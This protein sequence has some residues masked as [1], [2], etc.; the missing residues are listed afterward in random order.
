MGSE[1]RPSS[2]GTP[3]APPAPQLPAQ[4]AQRP[5]EQSLHPA[6]AKGDYFGLQKK[7]N[8]QTKAIYTYLQCPPS[9]HWLTR[10]VSRSSGCSWPPQG[11]L[12][13][14][15]PQP[16]GT[17]LGISASTRVQPVPIVQ[18]DLRRACWPSAGKMVPRD[19]TFPWDTHP[20]HQDRQTSASCRHLEPA[21]ERPALHWFW[22][23]CWSSL[24]KNLIRRTASG[25]PPPP[26]AGE[27]GLPSQR[28]DPSHGKGKQKQGYSKD[29]GGGSG[30]GIDLQSTI[31]KNQLETKPIIYSLICTK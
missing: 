14:A 30:L 10:D 24:A 16:E 11:R 13:R 20:L 26:R 29:E 7:K 15:E 23:S 25:P 1:G 2:E 6:N 8:E 9:R 12:Q 27:P 18:Q 17:V 22:V 3:R 28:R 19:R 5:A 21:A 31:K 4:A